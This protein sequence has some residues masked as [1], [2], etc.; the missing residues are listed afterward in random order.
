[1]LEKI[2]DGGDSCLP[3]HFANQH[4]KTVSSISTDHRT[5]S[6]RPLFFAQ[7]ARDAL[8][9]LNAEY[10]FIWVETSKIHNSVNFYRIGPI[11]LH[12]ATDSEIYNFASKPRPNYSPINTSFLLKNVSESTLEPKI[13]LS[14]LKLSKF[15]T[16]SPYPIE[17]F[18]E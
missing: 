14:E 18:F 17:P 13:S 16:N 10:Y 5:L 8:K 3:R 9:I 12:K 7:S 6:K 4:S 2:K 11:F 15:I 1:M